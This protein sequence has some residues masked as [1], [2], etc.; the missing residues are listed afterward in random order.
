[1]THDDLRALVLD[2][3]GCECIVCG[4]SPEKW[5]ESEDLDRSQDK[6]SIH[7]VNGDDSDDRLENLI[8][9]C[10]SCHTHIHRVDKPP[11]RK[12]HRQLPI[13]ARHAWNQHHAEYYEGDRISREEAERQFGSEGG[14][15]ESLKYKAREGDDA[16]TQTAVK[17]CQGR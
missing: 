16:A 10:Q 17:G 7:H 13:E 6:I 3:Y 8:P 14:D 2:K 4:R 11:Y 5:L 1:M 15:P 9:V 12:W